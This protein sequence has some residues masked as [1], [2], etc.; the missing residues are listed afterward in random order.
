MLLLDRPQFPVQ[1][2]AERRQIAPTSGYLGI[3]EL[4]PVGDPA[5]EIFI[6]GRAILYR[7]KSR[8]Q[9]LNSDHTRLNRPRAEQD[10]ILE[11]VAIQAGRH[12]LSTSSHARHGKM[13]VFMT[14]A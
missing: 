1:D 9:A 3:S 4:G 7:D 14:V 11:V 2:A 8:E 10:P 13:V 12:Y 6:V 5:R